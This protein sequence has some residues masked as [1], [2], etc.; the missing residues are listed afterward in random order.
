MKVSTMIHGIMISIKI[1]W[2]G[3]LKWLQILGHFFCKEVGYNSL[4]LNR[5]WPCD[6]LCQWNVV[7]C[8]YGL[9]RMGPK[10]P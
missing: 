1:T 3:R 2:R 4:P 9:P 5:S 6:S 7:Q 10:K 8:H